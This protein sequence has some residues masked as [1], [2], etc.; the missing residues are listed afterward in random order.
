MKEKTFTIDIMRF[1][2]DPYI[3]ISDNN[4]GISYWVNDI[5]DIADALQSYLKENYPNI[6]DNE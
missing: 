2:G 5:K 6:V 3:H 1:E 4:I